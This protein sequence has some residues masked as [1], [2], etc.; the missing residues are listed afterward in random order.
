MLKPFEKL[1]KEFQNDEVKKYYDILSKKKRSIILK[2][3]TD[4]VLA[5]FL[6]IVLALPML[7]IAF[8]IKISA[9]KGPV[10][11]KQVRV[12]QY[13]KEFKILKFRTMIVG[14]DQCGEL[15]T[16]EGDERVTLIGRALRKY[17]LDELPQIFHVLTGKMSIVGTRPEVIKYVERYEPIY[18]ATL[19]L[20]AGITSFASIKYKDEDKLLKEGDDVDEIYIKKIL[21]DKMKYNLKYIQRFGFRRDLFLMF[22]TLKEVFSDRRA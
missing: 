18:Y 16:K 17:R 6:I 10:F 1:P 3:I 8:I 9:T 22:K 21:P 15:L 19:L 12:T 7:L 2:R 5:I 14:S 13:G 4:I 11:Y 20:P